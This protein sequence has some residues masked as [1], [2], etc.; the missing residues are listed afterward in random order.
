MSY[1]NA[2]SPRTGEGV[3]EFFSK[4]DLEYA[5]DHKVTC[6]SDLLPSS[7]WATCHLKCTRVHR[8]TLSLTARNSRSSRKG[9]ARVAALAAGPGREAA[10]GPIAQGPSRSPGLNPSRGI[11][12]GVAT[13]GQSHALAPSRGLPLA[14]GQSRLWIAVPNQDLAATQL[15]NNIMIPT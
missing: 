6:V 9:V 12:P 8:I 3:V 10:P 14:R 11:D 4:R 2:H 5:L 1:A 15:T 13:R 7:L